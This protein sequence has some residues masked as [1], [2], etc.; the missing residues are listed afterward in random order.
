MPVFWSMAEPCLVAR[1]V[2]D[3]SLCLSLSQSL[4]LTIFLCLTHTHR[5][6]HTH[7]HTR[8][9][10]VYAHYKVLSKCYIDS[11]I[12]LY[13]THG[14]VHCLSPPPSW[15]HQ[16]GA[17][18]TGTAQHH[19]VRQSTRRAASFPLH[20]SGMRGQPLGGNL[21][22]GSS[23]I[24]PQPHEGVR[25]VRDHSQAS[26]YEQGGNMKHRCWR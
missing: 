18:N 13:F 4:S 20:S 3:L 17:A 2:I 10:H 14:H 21:G 1:S 7:T 6:T 26:P 15:P 16:H 19:H 9:L 8:H 25:G 11:M 23:P 24:W 5:H 22:P 12:P